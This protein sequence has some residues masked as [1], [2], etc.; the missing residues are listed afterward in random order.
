MPSN[1]SQIATYPR[2]VV[3]LKHILRNCQVLGQAASKLSIN[4]CAVTKGVCAELPI[5][6]TFVESGISVLGDSRLIN[7]QKLRHHFGKQVKLML[8]RLPALSEIDS[9]VRICDYSLVSEKSTLQALNNTA[10][11]LGTTHSVI[12]MIE[13]G[14]R[15]EGTPLKHLHSLV[16]F[17]LA[18]LSNIKVIGIGT[19]LS[20]LN[21][22]VVSPTKV[23]E[24]LSV[25]KK[26]NDEF[27]LDLLCSACNS[28]GIDLLSSN[29][30]NG[31]KPS[32]SLD[33]STK[34]MILQ[35]EIIELQVKPSFPD[36]EIGPNA[37][38]VKQV[39]KDIGDRTRAIIAIGKQDCVYEQLF[40]VDSGIVIVG[41]S[42][43][44]LVVDV[45]SSKITYSVGDI[46]NFHFAYGAMLSLF[47]SPYVEK[48]YL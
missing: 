25:R 29:G 27:G 23:Q 32:A 13:M 40:P 37:F 10:H 44:H 48:V 2:V 11:T 4:L 31:G 9:V 30:L 46:V 45:T 47:T 8:L 38:G 41:A 3:N 21:G 36:G 42:S 12:I 28:A 26:L 24:L 5:C 20:C 43:D 1:I 6:E 39:P 19:N 33:L 17:T 34:T 14:D 16:K 22:V 18:S 7:L 35:A 15:R